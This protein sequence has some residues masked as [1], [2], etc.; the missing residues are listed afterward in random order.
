MTNGLH[1]ISSTTRL[2]AIKLGKVL[3][4]YEECSLVKSH[5]PLNPRSFKIT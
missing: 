2:L 1:H 5:N 3:T 4:Y